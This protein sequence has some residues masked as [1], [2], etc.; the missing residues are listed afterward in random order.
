VP[1]SDEAVLLTVLILTIPSRA[2]FLRRLLDRLDAQLGWEDIN[3]HI[4][5]GTQHKTIGE[6]RQSALLHASGEY[7]VFVDDDDL[8]SNDYVPLI[9]EALESR[10]DCVGIKERRYRDGVFRGIAWH[11]KKFTHD[12][13]YRIGI[14]NEFRF[15]RL[16]NHICPTRTEIVRAVGFAARNRC[17]D[18]EYSMRL[19]DSG[20]LKS[21]V[22]IDEPIYDYLYRS[23]PSRSATD[24][25]DLKSLGICDAD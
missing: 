25:L 10:P 1:P 12:A 13:Q 4:E 5:D 3:V 22:L 20:L 8:P 17:D 11:D 6:C 15:D 2:Q 21:Q 14:E 7:C 24:R 19:R 9:L 18:V 16:I 23:R